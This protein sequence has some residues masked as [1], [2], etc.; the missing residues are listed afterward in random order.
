M[1]LMAGTVR[2]HSSALEGEVSETPRAAIQDSSSALKESSTPGASWHSSGDCNC[3]ETSFSPGGQV[4]KKH[5]HGAWLPPLQPSWFTPG[6]GSVPMGANEDQ[7]S[8]SPA[9]MSSEDSFEQSIQ[10]EIEQFLNDKD[11]RKT[12]SVMGL[13]IKKSDPSKSPARLRGNRETSARAALI[14]TC[15][16][17]IFRKP[18]KSTK[19]S[20]QPSNFRPKVTTEPETVVSTKLTPHRPEAAQN[21]GGVKRSMLASLS[22]HTRNSAPVHQASDSSSDDGIEEAFQLYQLEKTRN[23][24]CGDPPL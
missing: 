7:G 20:M 9:S 15:K 11:S 24:A 16:E 6:S 3:E 19:M 23:E 22:K 2:R 10:A 12:Q 14:G 17:F 18:P 21:R 8:M 5:H 1:A 4:F 13:W